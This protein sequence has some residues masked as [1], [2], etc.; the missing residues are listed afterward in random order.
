MG[1]IPTKTLVR[2]AKVIYTAHR[3]EEFGLRISTPEIDGSG[4]RARKDVIA[5]LISSTYMKRLD[6]YF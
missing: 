4:I 6:F 1:C 3:R 5:N 2:S